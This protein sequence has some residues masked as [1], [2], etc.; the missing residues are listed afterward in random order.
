MRVNQILA[1][2]AIAATVAM[3]TACGGQQQPAVKAETYSVVVNDVPVIC[4]FN[5]ETEKLI[6]AYWKE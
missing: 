3:A 2:A 4:F 1:I 6:S 5:D